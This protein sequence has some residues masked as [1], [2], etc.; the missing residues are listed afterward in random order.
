MNQPKVAFTLL[1]QHQARL[2]MDA[3]ALFYLP[4][5]KDGEYGR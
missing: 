2:A 3:F 4:S 5:S 1:H